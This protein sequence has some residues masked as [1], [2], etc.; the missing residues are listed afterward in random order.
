MHFIPQEWV[1]QCKCCVIVLTGTRFQLDDM[2]D[3]ARVS[4]YIFI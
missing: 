2:S 4:V 3:A 1:S